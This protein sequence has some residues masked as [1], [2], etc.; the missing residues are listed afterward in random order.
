MQAAG[1]D[2]PQTRRGGRYG[3][4]ITRR[5]FRVQRLSQPFRCVHQNIGDDAG[6][7]GAAAGDFRRVMLRRG[8][9]FPPHLQHDAPGPAAFPVFGQRR[10]F[11]PGRAAGGVN[12]DAVAVGA[13]DAG[14]AG[15]GVCQ[16]GS[17]A[18]AVVNQVEAARVGGK[19][20]GNGLRRRAAVGRSAGL[21]IQQ[22]VAQQDA[23]HQQPRRTRRQ[24]AD[25]GGHFSRRGEPGNSDVWRGRGHHQTPA[26]PSFSAAICRSRYFCTLPLEVIG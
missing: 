26:S 6:V 8:H 10:R 13:A 17:S 23:T 7:G 4:Q 15:Q 25:D 16:V 1:G 14:D 11:R 19:N 20:A 2:Q 3:A 18:G 9:G 5:P 21:P 12:L 24:R 22:G